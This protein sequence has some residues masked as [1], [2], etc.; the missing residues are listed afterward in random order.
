MFTGISPEDSRKIF[1]AVRVK[2][3]ARGEM[4]Y[5]EGETVGNVFLLISGMVK[6]T[7][8]GPKALEFTLKL[9]A[10]G[11][12][13][14][15][16]SLFSTGRHC[17]TAQAVQRC[18]ALVWDAAIFEALVEYSPVL[19]QNMVRSI[20]GQLRE[21]EERFRDLA[22]EPVAP[23]LARQL[24]RLQEQVGSPQKGEAIIG[25]SRAGLAHMTG[26]TLYTVSRLLSAWKAHGFV[27]SRRKCVMITDIRSLRKIIEES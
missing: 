21:L 13:L 7:Q 11:E 6:I 1:A 10:P 27:I 23:R 3:F 18:W 19:C 20:S 26:T 22:T 25:L 16:V 12:V 8:L 2:S 5:L 4:L 15:A 14:G 24:I 9:T 17:T